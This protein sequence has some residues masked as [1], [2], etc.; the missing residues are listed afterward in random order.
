MQ[1]EAV[2]ERLQ[3]LDR[4]GNWAADQIRYGLTPPTMLSY[5]LGRHTTPH[6]WVC[7]GFP[8]EISATIR[9]HWDFPDYNTWSGFD[10]LVSTP[11]EVWMGIADTAIGVDARVYPVSQFDRT[12]HALSPQFQQLERLGAAVDMTILDQLRDLPRPEP[13]DRTLMIQ[14]ISASAAALDGSI[15][16]SVS[17][18]GRRG[19]R[20]HVIA[21]IPEAHAVYKARDGYHL[22][23]KLEA[24]GVTGRA[25][26]AEHL[27]AWAQT[28]F[29]VYLQHRW[30]HDLN[31]IRTRYARLV[32]KSHGN[33]PTYNRAAQA[34]RDIAGH[35]FGGDVLAA[36]AAIDLPVRD[37]P[38]HV[39]AWSASRRSA[40]R[41][42]SPRTG[43]HSTVP[44]G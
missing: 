41:A 44:R 8:P 42:H 19:I 35:W 2:V 14:T 5:R 26:V 3:V 24:S 15:T 4:L 43:S 33:P 34:F 31:D 39:T 11:C 1:P 29:P 36:S 17:R 30:E 12:V 27:R 23:W 38:H 16:R 7:N 20:T 22:G 28:S 10:S 18:A 21:P 9:D 6:D 40:A 25:I 37:I 32:E 13:I